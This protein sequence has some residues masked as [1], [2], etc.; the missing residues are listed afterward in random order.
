MLSKEIMDIILNFLHTPPTL[1]ITYCYVFNINFKDI[2]YI[3]EDVPFREKE[4]YNYTYDD[5]NERFIPTL[6]I[7]TKEYKVLWYYSESLN[8]EQAYN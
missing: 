8:L 3:I 4:L 6:F 2:L 7:I 5:Y 1:S